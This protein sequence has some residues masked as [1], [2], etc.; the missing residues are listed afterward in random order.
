MNKN[1]NSEINYNINEIDYQE[2]Y[3]I[4]DN[5]IYKLV[6]IKNNNEII[7]RCKN[8]S[9]IFNKNNLSILTKTKFDSVND[10]YKYII[11][12]FEENKVII[13]NIVKNKEIKLAL[14]ISNDKM[15]EIQ[16]LFNKKVDFII[17]EVIKLKKD[18]NEIKIENAKLK[19]EINILKKYHTEENPKNIKLEKKYNKRFICRRFRLS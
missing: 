18:L 5:I 8:Y 15:L 17:D 1:Q 9:I 3:Q 6:I 19:E 2:Y 12:I 4:K 10:A 13:K 7:I 14:K 16:L 11:N